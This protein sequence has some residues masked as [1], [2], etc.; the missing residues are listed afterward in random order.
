MGYG[1][2]PCSGRSRL[3]KTR[4]IAPPGY[5]G[6]LL[7]ASGPEKQRQG[8]DYRRS[9]ATEQ[10]DDQTKPIS[11]NLHVFSAMGLVSVA[12]PLSDQ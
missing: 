2:F 10:Q 8:G 1:G 12:L 7:R 3:R 6:P 4:R 11:H 9:G 5:E